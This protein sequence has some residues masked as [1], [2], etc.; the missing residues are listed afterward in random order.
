MPGFLGFVDWGGGAP[1]GGRPDADHFARTLASFGG[2]RS[3]TESVQDPHGQW[4]VGSADLGVFR[5]A[6]L[7]AGKSV[8]VVLRGELD[9]RSL[10]GASS[11]D[12]GACA[13]AALYERD[14]VAGL[15]T[16]RGSFALA[17]V[18]TEN[19]TVVLM[20]DR[21]GSHPLYWWTHG[22]RLVFATDLGSLLRLRDESVQLDRRAV[23]DYLAFGFLTS[24]RTLA[25]N[26]SLLEAGCLLKWN[27]GTFAIDQYASTVRLYE[28]RDWSRDTYVAGV[29]DAFG[30]AVTRAAGPPGP[31]GMSLSG[32]LDSRAIL[33]ALGP[34]GA[35]AHSYTLGAAGCADEAIAKRLSGLTGTKHAFAELGDQYLTGFLE[36]LRR[37][38]SLT[39]GMY[40][41]HGL[42]E[43]LALRFLEGA[44]FKVLLRGHCGELLK[45]SLAWPLHTD[46]TVYTLRTSGELVDHLL[47]RL[48]RVSGYVGLSKVFT[49]SWAGQLAGGARASLED[50][51]R[52]VPLSP[53]ELC[54]YLYLH[55]HHR[56]FTVPSLDLFRHAVE[57]RLPFADDDFLSVLLSG[58]PEWRD[59]TD[60]HRAIVA[61][62]NPRL[63]AVRD[64]NTGAPLDA[65][66]L[67]F[68]IADKMNSL[69]KRL[70]VPGYRHYHEFDRWMERMLVRAVEAE[71]LSERSL[72][73]G[74][75]NRE[76]LGELLAAARRREHGSAYA[77]QVL[78]ILEL[79]QQENVDVRPHAGARQ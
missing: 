52:D 7:D 58:P 48:D 66:R 62:Y 79:W 13:I 73:R 70:G 3:R 56:R 63:L 18:D 14:G 59:S 40:L 72:D 35:E 19:R 47:Q 16:L 26:A 34:T 8:Q 30:E 76:G 64:S 53:P 4:A 1:V 78:L 20:T 23:A 24:T 54:S 50:S 28:R 12:G 17:V 5:G 43:I 67:T 21:L 33:S 71:L 51:V 69:L 6:C 60:L 11:G 61:R 39:D 41:S 29:V 22:S 55:E 15:K 38:V 74:I 36:S 9:P 65:G 31:L 2:T 49:S 42:T 45:T 10:S 75:L 46:Q 68:F 32:G 27:H 77:L 25:Q 37:M 44:P 57:I